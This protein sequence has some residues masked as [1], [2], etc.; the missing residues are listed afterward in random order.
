MFPFV[1]NYGN[2]IDEAQ[3]FPDNSMMM[4]IRLLIQLGIKNVALAGFDGY[5]PDDIN[6][7]DANM[8][9]S[10]VKEKADGLNKSGQKFFEIIKD[11]IDVEFVTTSYYQENLK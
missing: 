7:I 8:E 2:L 4:F 11:S 10:F 1:L 3:E 9:Y 5:T 6:Y